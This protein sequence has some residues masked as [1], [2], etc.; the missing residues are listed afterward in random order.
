MRAHVFV[1]GTAAVAVMALLVG[2]GERSEQAEVE[3]AL[4][5]L[6]V[7]DA[8]GLN[9]VMAQH[10]DPSEAV[11]YFERSIANEPDRIDFQRGLAQALIRAD[12]HTEAVAAW[13]RVTQH[14]ESGEDDRV[15]LAGALIRINDWE[16]ARQ[17]LNAIPPT[18]E[19]FERY[20]LEAM[21]ADA[22]QDW[23][24]ADSFYEI[25]LGLTTT[26]ASVLN[27]WG[28][29][30][31][32]RGDYDGAE[33][34]FI[35]ALRHDDD[36]FTAKNNLVLARAARREYDMPVIPMNQEERAQLL[37][38]A[39]LA[40]IKQNDVTIGRGLLDEAIE[41]HPRYFEEAVRAREALAT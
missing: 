21:V 6:N 41:S 26:P 5:D 9:D 2:C 15:A 34:L 20:R 36:L 30:K 28:Y 32:T 16:R 18:H 3:R 14:P 37:Y 13:E 39:A 10:A 11:A 19:T 35:D 7:I 25:A 40:A 33:R 22:A 12:R 24:R 29:S 1:R 38:T 23:D 17:T 4:A 8:S 27:N 31:L